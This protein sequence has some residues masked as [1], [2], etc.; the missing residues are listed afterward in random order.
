MLQA[1]IC[2]IVVGL[3]EAALKPLPVLP[4]PALRRRTSP[5]AARSWTFT[6]SKLVCGVFTT[7]FMNL[8]VLNVPLPPRAPPDT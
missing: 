7:Q 5:G 3:A 2:A 6:A 8:I 4:L 1:C